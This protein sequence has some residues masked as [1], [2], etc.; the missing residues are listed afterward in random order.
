M[1]QDG[2]LIQVHLVPRYTCAPLISS[3]FKFGPFHDICPHDWEIPWHQQHPWEGHLEGSCLH[4]PW[5][6]SLSLSC[7]LETFLLFSSS[8]LL[9][10]L[11]LNSLRPPH[12]LVM[13]PSLT[14]SS[15][16]NNIAFVWDKVWK[17]EETYFEFLIYVLCPSASF[18][19]ECLPFSYYLW[20]S[21][22]CKEY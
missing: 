20:V 7:S 1:L 11:L 15:F 21:F 9:Y 3:S 4:D 22:I 14:I 8:C 17:K 19:W 2:S 18:D 6:E 12:F 5:W 16:W 13:I 10:F